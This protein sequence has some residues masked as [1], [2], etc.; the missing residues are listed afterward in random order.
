ML[1]DEL[2]TSIQPLIK[3]PG[4]LIVA[5]MAIQNTHIVVD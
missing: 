1:T 4:M 3:L 2:T 5:E